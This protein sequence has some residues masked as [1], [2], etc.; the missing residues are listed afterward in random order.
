MF[1]SRAGRRRRSATT[2]GQFV[3]ASL[4]ATLLQLTEDLP[5]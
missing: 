4:P 3:S 5:R 1:G 2:L